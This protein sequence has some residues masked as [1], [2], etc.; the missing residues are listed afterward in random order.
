MSRRRRAPVRVDGLLARW[1]RRKNLAED[2]SRHELAV[3]WGELVGDRLAKRTRPRPLADDGTL[4]IV[5]ASSAWLN[6][7][8]FLRE[9]L[10]ARI[11]ERLG[12]VAVTGVRL[13]VG[14]LSA[15]GRRS[16]KVDRPD[17]QSGERAAWAERVAARDIPPEA[18][19]DEELRE[20]I[21]AA[22]SAQLVAGGPRGAVGGRSRSADSRETEPPPTKDP[23]RSG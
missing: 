19:A 22:R 14:R 9:E 21:R 12:R 17:P 20:R 8:S 1:I 4:T 10:R 18:V 2:F 16:A 23:R 11:N 13:V 6:E 3:R 15:R 5:V 7:L